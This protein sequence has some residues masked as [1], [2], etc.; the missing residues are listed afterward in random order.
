MMEKINYNETMKQII[1]NL[2]G[3]KT[4]LLHSCCAP[5]SSS[6]IERISKFFDIT[7][8]YFNPNILPKEE[9]ERRKNEQIRLIEEFNKVAPNKINFIDGD[10]DPNVFSKAIR[11]FENE[12][13]G[14]E[15]CKRC[16][17]FRLERAAE[18]ASKMNFDFFGTT[19][20]ISP[21]KNSNWI[22]EILKEL[23]NKLKNDGFKTRALFAD[24][25]KENGFLRSLELSK[26]FGLF[27]QDYCGCRPTNKKP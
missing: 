6:V 17:E 1:N 26:Q 27:R 15:R 11:G 21:H 24:F 8:F 14:S 9:Y 22:N 7:V 13:E 2:E 25:K 20:S 5:C 10:Y 19:L 4:L 3:R 23:E 12:V 18:H 16:Y